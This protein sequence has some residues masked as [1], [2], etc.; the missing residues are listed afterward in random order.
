[1]SSFQ[2]DGYV[3]VESLVDAQTI[4]TISQYFENKINRGEWK[5]KTEVLENDASKLGYYA[6]PLIE[7]ILKQCLPAIE[8]QTGLELEPTYSFSR[9]YQEGEELTP[10]T[11]RP[12]CE[13][14]ATINVACT[15]D[16]WPIW[17]QYE[18][19]DPVKCMLESGD[20]V[21]YKGCEVTHWRR[22]L[23]KG[24]INVQFMLHYVD[25][26]GPNAEYKFDK[27]EALGLDSSARRS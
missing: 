7:V 16:I 18:D 20:A 4:K 2:S 14:S 3:K 23:P 25:K 13:I 10:H 26:N 27:R 21:I 1:M 17:M 9:V 5:A 22:K 12:S 24:H 6:D 8:E 15:G 11:D 19:N